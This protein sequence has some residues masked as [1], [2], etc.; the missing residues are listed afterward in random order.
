[1]FSDTPSYLQ[2]PDTLKSFPT[3]VTD[4]YLCG[5]LVR[6]WIARQHAKFLMDTY[7]NEMADYD[8]TLGELFFRQKRKLCR[9]GRGGGWHLWLQQNGITRSTADRLALRF[10]QEH[11]L[12]DDLAHRTPGDRLQGDICLAA[13]RD[14][15]R[16]NKYLP[17]PSNRMTYVQV[18]ADLLDLRVEW[19]GEAVRLSISPL[20]GSEEWANP[21]VP[22][23]M[24][25]GSDG[26]FVPVN[27]ELKEEGVL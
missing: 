18:L 6:I 20:E 13:H 12:T 2:N 10:A 27:Y 21:V 14:G 19:E 15:R 3:S 4:P 23:V 7:K 5:E 11:G 17:S 8:A 26:A 9:Q 22:S 24:V 16:L 1:M 25:L